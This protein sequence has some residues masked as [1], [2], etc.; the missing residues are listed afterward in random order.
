MSTTRGTPKKVWLPRVISR[1]PTATPCVMIKSPN[2]AIAADA[3]MSRAIAVPLIAAKAS[4]ASATTGNASQSE[5]SW[6]ARNPG[7]SGREVRWIPAGMV[8]I[9]DR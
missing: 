8:S 1:A 2:E 4:P 9:P 5:S 3:P 6:P 7:N